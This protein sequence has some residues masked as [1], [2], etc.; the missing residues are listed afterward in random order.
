MKNFL[1][2]FKTLYK[3]QNVRQVSLNGKKKLSSSVKN[4]LL[5]LPFS[6]LF[7]I[8]F[9]AMTA[10]IPDVRT[11]ALAL[12]LILSIVQLFVLF[13]SMFRTLS[14]LYG[15]SDIPF[16]NTLPIK[17]V[18]VFA[19]RFLLSYLEILKF[20]ASFLVPIFLTMAIA[21][22]V[23]GPDMFY[24]FF[25]LEFIIV[26]VAPV[27]PL[28]VITIFSMPL[29]Y[30]GSF[31]K[32]KPVVKT[33][34]AFLAYMLLM[35]GYM[36]LIFK[37]NEFGASEGAEDVGALSGA[38]I[39]GLSIFANVMYPNKVLVLWCLGI[40]AGK[41]FG[42]SFAITV[43]ML[44]LI[45][46]LSVLFFKRIS[47]KQLE[48]RAET[49]KHSASFKQSSKV[50]TLMKKD[51]KSIMRNTRIAM[52][53]FANIIICPVITV[54]MYFIYKMQN[55][56]GDMSKEA[57]GALTFG[58]AVLYTIIFQCASNQ[59]S[60]LAYTREGSAFILNK[61]LPIRAKDSMLSKLLLCFISSGIII[62]VQ[63]II[64]LALYK[65]HIANVVLFVPYM[66]LM[67]L[68]CGALNILFDLKYG[69]NNWSTRQDLQ[70]I[71]RQNK[72]SILLC[73]GIVIFAIIPFGFLMVSAI[74]QFMSTVALYAIYWVINYI[75]AIV[76]AV[77][78][79]IALFRNGEKLYESFG[80]KKFIS[81]ARPQKNNGFKGGS[82]LR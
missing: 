39:K 36:A 60:I 70:Q 21:Y 29:S 9:G 6:L 48:A 23:I 64:C 2:L 57:F 38:A 62:I 73:F 45:L 49:V 77:V 75:V 81:K 19:A 55:S 54:F 3:N 31:F 47:S 56:D 16:L 67:T 42:I 27:L 7:C 28:F 51:F 46:L 33:V 66:L 15:T 13:L 68:G 14:L 30:I 17:P 41:N 43:G 50:V 65:T 10:V 58:I 32:G 71:S 34:L 79:P 40:E 35:C 8:I 76:L 20:T 11:L 74:M 37:M 18:S 22:S 12:T 69:N 52:S 24:G 1:L 53:S 25:A 72:G 26:L 61:T 80:E 82:L 59:L 63:S 5:T 4:F 44:A 78:G